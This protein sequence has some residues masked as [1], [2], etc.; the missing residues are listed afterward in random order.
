MTRM[1]PDLW[2]EIIDL[3]CKMFSSLRVSKFCA[4]LIFDVEGPNQ[5]RAREPPTCRLQ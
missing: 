1:G 4:G 5:F 2:I 3:F